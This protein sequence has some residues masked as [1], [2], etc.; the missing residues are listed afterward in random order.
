LFCLISDKILLQY[1]NELESSVET[2]RSGHALALGALP[3]AF[4]TGTLDTIV[5]KLMAA[6]TVTPKHV[7]FVTSRRDCLKAL[8]R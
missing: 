4:L 1:L 2:A 7:A 3:L 6:A 8:T 5:S